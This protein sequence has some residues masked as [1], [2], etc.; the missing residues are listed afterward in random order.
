[1]A[2]GAAA[3]LQD[4]YTEAAILIDDL[5]WGLH[6]QGQTREAREDVT[7]GIALLQSIAEPERNRPEVTE[8]LIKAQR[9]LVTFQF[10][11]DR[12]ID[13]ALKGVH[14][15]AGVASS[16]PQPGQAL[17]VA[18]LRHTEAA[19]IHQHLDLKLGSKGQVD[20]TGR[21]HEL[22]QQA[23]DSSHAAEASFQELGDVERQLKALKMHA[24]LLRHGPQST[25]L[26]T[27]ESRLR[28]LETIAS[29]HLS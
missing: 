20:P 29:R 12:D 25:R 7:D 19:L 27:A 17:H 16:L 2:L 15:L 8:L 24:E 14:E 18:Q 13:R 10:S 1:L 4:R 28:R 6:V 3:A 5:G 9:H 21:L 23:L 11:E 26:H 22:Y